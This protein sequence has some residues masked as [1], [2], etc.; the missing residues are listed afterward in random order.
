VLG[1]PAVS[2]SVMG[3]R[4]VDDFERVARALSERAELLPGER[5]ALEAYGAR[6]RAEKDLF[7]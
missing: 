1:H 6:V 4:S 5:E 2:L 7:G 3:L